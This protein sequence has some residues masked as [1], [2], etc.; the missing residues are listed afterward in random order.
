VSDEYIMDKIADHFGLPGDPETDGSSKRVFTFPSNSQDNFHCAHFLHTKTEI[1]V[2]VCKLQW[3]GANCELRVGAFKGAN[4]VPR[5][6]KGASKVGILDEIKD[7]LLVRYSD[8]SGRLEQMAMPMLVTGRFGP[9]SG[10]I[11]VKPLRRLEL[12]PLGS[13]FTWKEG[14]YHV[15]V[16]FNSLFRLEKG[17][18]S[19]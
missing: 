6:R 17:L 15:Q 5:Y 18:I 11:S 16:D 3:T 1:F 12:N 2:V 13:V 8:L 7:E 10:L 4:I 19:H 9:R 14:Y